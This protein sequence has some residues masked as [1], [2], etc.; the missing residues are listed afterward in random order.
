MTW[1]MSC[2]LALGLKIKIVDW[3][4]RTQTLPYNVMIGNFGRDASLTFVSFNTN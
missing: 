2:W 1:G 3:G 4:L